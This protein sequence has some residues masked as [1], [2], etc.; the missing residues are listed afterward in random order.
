MTK[1][2][3]HVKSTVSNNEETIVM[4]EEAVL[5]NH[6]ITAI[7]NGRSNTSIAGSMH[8]TTKQMFDTMINQ[9]GIQAVNVFLCWQ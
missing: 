2:S 6:D 5:V 7:V 8:S 1:T 9:M 4:E 3:S